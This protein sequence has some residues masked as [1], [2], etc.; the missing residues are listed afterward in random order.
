MLY[1]SVEKHDMT[2]FSAL[3][4][5]KFF[6]FERHHESGRCPYINIMQFF[7]L[8]QEIFAVYLAL[9]VLVA[10]HEWDCFKYHALV[11]FHRA[12]CR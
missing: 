6:P 4:R 3:N 5:D 12:E 7:D 10:L 11:V 1:T 2:V 9:L 8:M